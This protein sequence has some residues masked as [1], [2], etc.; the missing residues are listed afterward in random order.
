[1]QE[2]NGFKEF[3]CTKDFQRNGVSKLYACI[4]FI[5]KVYTKIYRTKGRL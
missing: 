3:L 5:D 1:M 2:K 4:Q